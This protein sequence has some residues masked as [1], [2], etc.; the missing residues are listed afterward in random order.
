MEQPRKDRLPLEALAR[1]RFELVPLPDA[2]EEV[3]HLPEGA[4]VAVTCSPAR[5]IESTLRFCEALSGRGFEAVPHL[6]ARLVRS[7]AHLE[8]VLSRLSGTREVFVVGGDVK[9]PAG[10]F[11]SAV[12][13]LSAMPEGAF[14]RVGIAG[15]PERHPLIPEED[16]RRALHEKQPFATYI[17]TQMCFDPGRV[18]AWIPAI[19]AEGIRLQVYVGMPGAVERSKLIKVSLKIGVGD[20]VRF[21][22]S[23]AGLLKG[24]LGRYGP[25]ALVEG[26]APYLGDRRYDIRGFHLFTFNQVE[27]TERWRRN[28]IEGA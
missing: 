17:V 21:L 26:L 4:K 20:S 7:E 22:K 15:Y 11:S 2:M 3:R 10:P 1:P 16:L 12:E 27:S 14:E 6:S 28:F 18:V 9:E 19:R 13:L 23:H 8:E 25:E 24:L 5:G